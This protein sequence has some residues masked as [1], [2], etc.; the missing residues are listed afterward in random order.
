M[1][2]VEPESSST[3]LSA[4]YVP[5]QP[6]H[7]ARVVIA[8]V[9][10]VVG[11]LLAA[12]ANVVVWARDTA[13]DTDTYVDTVLPI[14]GDEDIQTAVAEFLADQILEFADLDELVAE[15]LPN[16]LGELGTRLGGG[17]EALARDFIV[18]QVEDFL[19]SDR[20][21]EIF[22][23]VNREGH[24]LLLDAL[25]DDTALIRI[26][27]DEIVLDLDDT[28]QTINDEIDDR[29][30]VNIFASGVDNG[31][32]EYV[33]YESPEI[34]DAKRALDTLDTLDGIL[35]WLAL[36]VLVAAVAVAPRR[37]RALW[38]AAA[39]VAVAALL[40]LGLEVFAQWSLVSSITDPIDQL[41]G[42]SLWDIAARGL[43][44]QT[45]AL[46]AISAVVAIAAFVA[47]TVRR[48][49]TGPPTTEQ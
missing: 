2:G 40:F 3:S 8:L 13:L 9:L 10:V 11:S 23:F 19:Q 36:G 28:L 24:E 38:W 42:D 37:L 22:T 7:R 1:T 29:W 35:P 32:A 18:E 39:G 6:R 21:A 46:V 16:S 4:N 15:V 12:T 30:G 25:T 27:G 20:A 17:A 44:S 47:D 49:A 43:V 34:G 48:R 41:A 14:L 45:I 33:L 5:L 31:T 26:K